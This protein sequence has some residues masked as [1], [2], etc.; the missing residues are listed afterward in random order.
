MRPAKILLRLKDERPLVKV[1][2]NIRERNEAHPTQ[3]HL[4]YFDLHQGLDIAKKEQIRSVLVR[5]WPRTRKPD[6]IDWDDAEKKL[7][8]LRFVF[9]EHARRSEPVPEPAQ[10]LAPALD[11]RSST[12]STTLTAPDPLDVSLDA[13]AEPTQRRPAPAP[14]HAEL[15]TL[16]PILQRYAYHLQDPRERTTLSKLRS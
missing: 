8:K 16:L 9:A 12:S 2:V 15:V 1:F 3:L 10:P 7:A 13:T 14:W 4:A 5:R 6:A 11:H